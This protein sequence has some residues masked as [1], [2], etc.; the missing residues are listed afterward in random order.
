MDQPQLTAAEILFPDLPSEAASKPAAAPVARP[1]PTAAPAA[2]AQAQAT[3]ETAE[4]RLE[5]L[6]PQPAANGQEKPA[7]AAT[8]PP[9]LPDFIDH[10]HADAPLVTPIVQELGLGR[11]QTAK[12]EI[13]HQQMTAAAIDRQSDAW[14]T[15]AA[16]LPPQDIRDAQSAV[17]RFGSPELKDVLNKTGIGNHPA[18]IRAFAK[19][20][21]SNPYTY[22]G[23]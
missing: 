7:A 2:P 20:L 21:R 8:E 9:A 1:Q 23:Y 17:A 16:R 15:E 19:A 13:L 4:Q 14:A 3:E 6:F 18:V 10:T 11:E 22:R 5:R 12:L